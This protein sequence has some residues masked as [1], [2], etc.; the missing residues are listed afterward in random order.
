MYLKIDRRPMRRKLRKL[1]FSHLGPGLQA[2]T[3]IKYDTVC[4][5]KNSQ[6]WLLDAEGFVWFPRRMMKMLLA[7]LAPVPCLLV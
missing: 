1:N 7:A 2:V 3:Y 5:Y 6:F 4:T